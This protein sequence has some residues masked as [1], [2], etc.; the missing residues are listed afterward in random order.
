MNRKDIMM[1]DRDDPLAHCRD[2]FVR[3]E[4]QIY[5]DANSMGAMPKTV[6]GRMADFFQKGWVEKRRQGWNAFEWL[7]RPNQ[8]GDAIA[9]LVGAGPGECLAFDNTTLNLYKLIGYALKLRPDRNVILTERSNFPTDLYVVQGLEERSSGG[10]VVRYVEEGTDILDA[11]GDDVAVVYLTH[12]DYRSSRRRDMATINEKAKN[13]GALTLWDLSHSAGAVPVDLNGS[14]TDFAVGCGYKYLSGGPGGPAWL[15]VNKK[16]H[17]AGWPTICGWIG[18]QDYFAFAEEYAP[19]KGVD[20]HMTGTPQVIANEIFWCAAE[21][22]N[23][24]DPADVAA[25][26]R[27]LGEVVISMIDETCSQYGAEIVSPRNYDERGGHICIRVPGG[28]HVVEALLDRGVVSSFRKPDAI[29]FGL[30]A[31]AHSHADMVEVVDRLRDI[32]ATEAWKDQKY[33]TV[34]V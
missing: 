25:K 8:I 32:L 9:R 21:I 26:H 23:N 33:Q 6:P 14:G 3:N 19:G 18:H 24:V 30:S 31:L 20:R 7:Q 29:R 10:L 15:Y 16:H 34:S 28:G 13:S 11:I 5:L 2:L 17:D 12:V 1:L 22:W 4:G 27:S